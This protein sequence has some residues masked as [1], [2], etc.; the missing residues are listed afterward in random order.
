MCQWYVS[1]HPKNTSNCAAATCGWILCVPSFHI[2]Q[3]DCVRIERKKSSNGHR[4]RQT[5]PLSHAFCIRS[6]KSD[7]KDENYMMRT[8]D[9]RKEKVEGAKNSETTNKF[10][11]FF[12][13][14]MLWRAMSVCFSFTL[15]FSVAVDAHT[16]ILHRSCVVSLR[17]CVNVSR[18]HGSSRFVDCVNMCTSVLCMTIN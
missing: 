2:Y 6:D 18:V 11:F 3:V 12:L 16:P 7:E 4:L 14:C 8:T 1:A 17:V 15:N 13:H 10:C 9:K 5:H